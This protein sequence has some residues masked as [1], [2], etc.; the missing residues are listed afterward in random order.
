MGIKGLT[1]FICGLIGCF[2]SKLPDFTCL[3]TNTC[4]QTGKNST[5]MRPVQLSTTAIS[6]QISTTCTLATTSQK[7]L[8]L[9]G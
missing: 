5:V 6:L 2:K 9:A 3:V 7:L 4:N 8:K 1:V